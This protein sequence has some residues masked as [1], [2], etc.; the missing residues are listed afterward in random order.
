MDANHVFSVIRQYGY[1]FFIAIVL[2]IVLPMP[3]AFAMEAVQL[4]EKMQT[5]D[6]LVGPNLVVNPGFD[7]ELEPEGVG[8]TAKQNAVRV[9]EG[10]DGGWVVRSEQDWD[11]SHGP[12]HQGIGQSINVV[13]SQVYDVSI[14]F[15]L[16]D[17]TGAHVKFTWYD[18]DGNGLS[19]TRM[20]TLNPASVGWTQFT[21]HLWAPNGAA[22]VDIAIWHGVDPETD[23]NVL[24]STLLIDDVWFSARTCPPLF[25]CNGDF[26]VGI[27][28]WDPGSL[29]VVP[30]LVPGLTGQGIQITYHEADHFGIEQRLN[31]QFEAG[32]S[33]LLSAWCHAAEDALC[34]LT[35]NQEGGSE[36]GQALTNGN[37]TWQLFHEVI[38]FTKTI[39]RI[40]YVYTS[41]EDK[42]VIYD[43][44]TVREVTPVCATETQLS[45]LEC[46]A[47]VAIYESTGGPN[48][49]EQTGWLQTNTPCDW[50]GVS[51]DREEGKLKVS[52]L[53]LERIQAQGA[54]PPEI[55]HLSA[56]T[57]LN[58]GFNQLE[59]IPAEIG[60]LSN[61]TQLHLQHNQ[62]QDLPSEIGNLSA[63][64]SLALNNNQLQDLPSEIGTLSALTSL[65]LSNNQLT[66]I[67]TSL[68]NLSLLE[69][70][71]LDNN[72]F[73][74]IPTEI[75]NL[76]KL[77]QLSLAGN[78]LSSLPTG[79]SNLSDLTVLD[80]S[81]NRFLQFPMT[82]GTFSALT[83]LNLSGNL[84]AELP[85]DIIHFCEQTAINLNYN[86]LPVAETNLCPSF[87]DQA[88]T[89]TI[90][91]IELT[92][93]P[94]MGSESRIQFIWTPILY[95]GEGGYYEVSIATGETFR[96]VGIP[97]NKSSDG[98]VITGIDPG[99][100]IQ[101]RVR[102]YAPVHGENP[103][104]LWSDYSEIITA[105]ALSTDDDDQDPPPFNCLQNVTTIP[106]KECEA[107][108]AF[109]Y[110]LDGPNWAEHID[111]FKD[112]DP[113][114]W[115]NITCGEIS[116]GTTI[117]GLN[118][119]AFNEGLVG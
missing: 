92:A 63:L 107:L 114:N 42:P 72:Q 22:T 59:Q 35:L 17:A 30:T 95:Q 103:N 16:G 106:E 4:V 108:V 71:A 85:N 46:E 87:S 43:N 11:A 84:L 102:T 61:L 119:V 67:P 55:A 56:L 14:W 45:L 112:D 109:F 52:R 89:Q 8:W 91:P 79:I 97:P 113:C 111:W 115:V 5:Q 25:I 93:E 98:F 60:L 37:G 70:L 1:A 2:L 54:L 77:N 73:A 31:G 41:T 33:Y 68:V 20:Q 105:T 83:Q 7:H 50:S 116:M 15:D 48:W 6:M 23:T 104:E 81:H 80:V 19:V 82:V 12:L 57:V 94:Y 29:D 69:T 88:G 38:T 65:V 49:T 74:T 53:V 34:R 99:A 13:S 86:R 64:T 27:G 21:E 76:T 47:L 26:E 118:F 78:S 32:K 51:C 3:S 36:F 10:R 9:E 58:L 96:V 62:L 110:S 101:M 39:P 75:G 44:I 28:S 18:Q 40:F 90:A 100:T 24:G 66:S 117:T